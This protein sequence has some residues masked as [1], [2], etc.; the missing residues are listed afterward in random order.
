MESA[1]V[2]AEEVRSF[3]P[4]MGDQGL[5]LG[6]FQLEYVPQELSETDLDLLSF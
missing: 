2:I 1:N 5:G 4:R 3:G 6:Q